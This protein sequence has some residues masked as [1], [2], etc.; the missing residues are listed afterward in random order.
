ML[1]YG[2]GI[3]FALDGVLMIEGAEG[4]ANPAM[5]P[6]GPGVQ[7]GTCIGKLCVDPGESSWEFC[8]A[9]DMWY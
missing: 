3:S 5:G 1:I 2:N 4:F 9:V 8:W 6:E 7:L